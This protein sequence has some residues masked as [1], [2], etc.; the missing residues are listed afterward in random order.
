M[1]RQ[2][3]GRHHPDGEKDGEVDRRGRWYADLGWLA[4]LQARL[5]DTYA[6]LRDPDG[7]GHRLWAGALAWL[8]LTAAGLT[9]LWATGAALQ[10]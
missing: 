5:A 2:I 6:D 10:P 3:H 7:T 4:T 8:T 9:A 1:R